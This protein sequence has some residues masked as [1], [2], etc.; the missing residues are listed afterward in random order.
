MQE[1]TYARRVE[2]RRLPAD[3]PNILIVLI[4]DAGPGLPSTFGGEV[5]TDTLTR[6]RN[7][8]IGYNRFQTTAMWFADP[9][10]SVGSVDDIGAAVCED[11]L[12]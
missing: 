8:G 2:P 11:V 9:L 6:I 10:L 3:L 12:I 4:D 5:R 1:W 7:E